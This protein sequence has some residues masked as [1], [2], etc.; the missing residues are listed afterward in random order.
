MPIFDASH[1]VPQRIE[2]IPTAKSAFVLFD[3]LGFLSERVF[4]LIKKFNIPTA[5]VDLKL[6]NSNA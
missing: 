2:T 3:F 6:Q 5:L 1:V 4:L